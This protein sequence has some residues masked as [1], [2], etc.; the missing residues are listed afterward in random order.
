MQIFFNLLINVILQD[1]DFREIPN[2]SEECRMRPWGKFGCMRTRAW[3]G[4]Y[5]AR[6]LGSCSRACGQR[7]K[8]SSACMWETSLDAAM[9]NLH[10]CPAAGED[11]R[12][13]QDRPE[14]GCKFK[15]G[16]GLWFLGAVGGGNWWVPDVSYLQQVGM[17]D[18][19]L[20]FWLWI[21]IPLFPRRAWALF[22]V[23]VPRQPAR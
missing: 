15:K 12:Y 21:L 22:R 5:Q 18:A 14:M 6:T 13:H 11:V 17:G 19:L 8:K 16:H 4:R 9:L 3:S 1:A 23:R 20:S 7:I 2:A 10:R